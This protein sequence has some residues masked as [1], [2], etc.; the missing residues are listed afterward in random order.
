MLD[1]A[2]DSLDVMCFVG[3][4]EQL[5]KVFFVLFVM[6]LTFFYLVQFI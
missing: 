3:I 2:P 5:V 4:N 6:L 1:L